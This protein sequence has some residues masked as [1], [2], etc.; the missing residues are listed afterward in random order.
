MIQKIK[1]G[2]IWRTRMDVRVIPRE[3]L[4][5]SLGIVRYRTFQDGRLLPKV[6]TITTLSMD[7]WIRK[8]RCTV[9]R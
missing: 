3:V 1:P 6:R 7:S 9:W 4:F 5:A 2:Q 8:W